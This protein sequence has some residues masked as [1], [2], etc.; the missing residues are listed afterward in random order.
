MSI[1]SL[2]LYTIM[3]EKCGSSPLLVGQAYDKHTTPKGTTR[4]KAGLWSRSLR[5]PSLPSVPSPPSQRVH[6]T[7]NTSNSQSHPI[8]FPP[9][10]IL[11][12]YLSYS[13]KSPSNLDL[14]TWTHTQVHSSTSI[15]APFLIINFIFFFF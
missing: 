12:T 5:S 6:T 4:Q 10:K 15:F 7:S 9:D 8:F 3:R 14:T 2:A 1:F 13:T 11:Q